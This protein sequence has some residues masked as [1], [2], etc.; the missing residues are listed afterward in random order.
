MVLVVGLRGWH[1]GCCLLSLFLP[2]C[3]L[4][5][6][7]PP[8]RLPCNCVCTLHL[9]LLPRAYRQLDS[10]ATSHTRPDPLTHRSFA[11]SSCRLLQPAVATSTHVRRMPD[12]C[13]ARKCDESLSDVSGALIR[14]RLPL[15]LCLLSSP[16]L[17]SCSVGEPARRPQLW[18][19]QH[20]ATAAAGCRQNEVRALDVCSAGLGSLSRACHAAG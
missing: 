2:P 5:A 17:S 13:G 6:I 8:L 11:A 12:S 3:C 15:L 19:V 14:S 7:L 20:T 18:P 1:D 9:V 10:C 4:R 16:L